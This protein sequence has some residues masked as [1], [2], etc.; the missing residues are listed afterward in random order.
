MVSHFV[1]FICF[2]KPDFGDFE[3]LLAHI[4]NKKVLISINDTNHI[5]KRF[6]NKC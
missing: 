6:L 2:D 3:T 4:L 5:D 1:P